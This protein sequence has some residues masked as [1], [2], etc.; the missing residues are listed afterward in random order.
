MKYTAKHEI[1]SMTGYTPDYTKENQDYSCFNSF[2]THKETTRIYML[3]DGHGPNGHFA[4][5]FCCETIMNL[6]EQWIS[7]AKE[8]ELTD[9]K[10][11]EFLKASF[12]ETHQRMQNTDEDVRFYKYSGTTMIVALVRKCTLYLANLGDSRAL[13]GSQGIGKLVPS[14][15]TNDH[16]PDDPVEKRRIEEA[17]GTVKA[18][19][20]DDGTY[21][22]PAR[23]WNEK[24]TEPGLATS[25]SLG[26][27]LAHRYGV[28]PSPG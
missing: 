19:R 20:E 21:S 18:F 26:D 7:S 11:K 25:R 4:S 9:E 13:L 8:D 1:Y 3:A 2:V 22:G 10:I 14:L 16:K 6:L 28:I 27:L 15:V 23:V 12:E 5:K 17:G 24:Q